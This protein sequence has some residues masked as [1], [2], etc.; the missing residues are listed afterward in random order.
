MWWILK[1][2]PFIDMEME[3]TLVPLSFYGKLKY[4]LCTAPKTNSHQAL[5]DFQFLSSFT[6]SHR[7]C[8]SLRWTLNISHYCSQSPLTMMIIWKNQCDQIEWIIL[9]SSCPLMQSVCYRVLKQKSC[10]FSSPSCG[11]FCVCWNTSDC[12]NI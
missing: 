4:A 6:L 11:C 3:T 10:V 8:I 12:L 9:M 2:K 5:F 7:K 1:G